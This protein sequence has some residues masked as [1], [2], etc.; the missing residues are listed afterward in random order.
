VLTE[1][2]VVLYLCLGGQA[3]RIVVGPEG[4]G[5]KVD[6]VLEGLASC[7]GLRQMVGRAKD[8]WEVEGGAASCAWEE[9]VHLGLE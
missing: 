1:T 7:L 6:H 3:G 5:Q 9:E 2:G 8:P 4:E